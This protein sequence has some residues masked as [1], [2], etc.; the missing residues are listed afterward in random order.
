MIRYIKAATAALFVV[1]GVVPIAVQ[2]A[3]TKTK[4]STSKPSAYPTDFQLNDALNL[5]SIESTALLKR[6]MLSAG[7]SIDETVEINESYLDFA[8]RALAAEKKR[9]QQIRDALREKQLKERHGTKVKE[10]EQTCSAEDG[11]CKETE[12]AAAESAS[13]SAKKQQKKKQP[14]KKEEFGHFLT[15]DLKPGQA[16]VLRWDSDGSIV[17]DYAARVGLPPQL[18]PT[19]IEYIKDMGLYDIMTNMLYDDPLPPD[20]A[21][22]FSFQSP[23]QTKDPAVDASQIR[24]F[25]WNVERPAKKWKSDMHWFNTADELSHEDA[26][27]ALSKGGFDEVLKGIGEQFGLDTL[28]VDSFGFVSVTHCERGFIHT[29]WEDVDGRAFNFLLG[30]YSPDDAG[31]ELIVESGDGSGGGKKGE[32]YYGTNAGVLVGDGTRHGTREC[33]HRAKKEVRITCSIYLAD[34]TEENLDILAGDTTSVFPPTGDGPGKEWIWTQRGRHWKKDE[35]GSGLVTDKGRTKFVVV[36]D[37]EEGCTEEDCTNETDRGRNGCLKTC[38]V[39]IEDGVY[40]PGM[41]RREV[42]G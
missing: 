3:D 7:F 29:D 6:S 18:V 34:P 42:L 30:I 41:E 31:P 36:E 15:P 37:S 1:S 5:Y 9:I 13:T 39:F 14:K 21:E 25:T 22:W 23:Y 38:K 20:G 33:D 24:N 40:K 12:S 2:A 19:L 4:G 27:R 32:T 10:Q 11:T 26:I 35:E 17:Q 28:H 8:S 16:S